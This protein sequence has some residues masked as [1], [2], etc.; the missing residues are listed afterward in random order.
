M[1]P[2][3]AKIPGPH[4]QSDPGHQ[5]YGRP[6]TFVSQATSAVADLRDF[7]PHWVNNEGGSSGR[8]RVSL[9]YVV[10]S[11]TRDNRYGAHGLAKGTEGLGGLG[12]RIGESLRTRENSPELAQA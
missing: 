8:R 6:L 12:Q 9:I 2:C 10:D 7:E 3:T 1:S 5:G 11:Q 4:T